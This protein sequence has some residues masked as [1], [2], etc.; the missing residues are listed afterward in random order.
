MKKNINDIEF[1]KK[2]SF[3]HVLSIITQFASSAAFLNLENQQS[4]MDTAD[5]LSTI[6]DKICMLVQ[7]YII[8]ISFR[9]KIL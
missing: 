4:K 5:G 8:R 6:V 9:R 1:S 7:C 3:M 2:I